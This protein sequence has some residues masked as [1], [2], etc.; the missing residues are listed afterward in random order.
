MRCSTRIPAGKK[1]LKRLYLFSVLQLLGRSLPKAI[2]VD[3]VL[4]HELEAL[5]QAFTFSLGIPASGPSVCFEKVAG[6]LRRVRKAEGRGSCDLQIRLNDIEAA[7]RLLT[8]QESTVFSAAR[9]R[10]SI[11]GDIAT[12]SVVVRMLDRLEILLLPAF[13]ARRAVRRYKRLPRPCS[14]RLRI[15]RRIIFSRMKRSGMSES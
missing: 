10:I 3:T 6:G 15:Y 12:G 5:P 8:L 7:F 9:G 2:E 13:L 11:I 4:S 1:P 14:H